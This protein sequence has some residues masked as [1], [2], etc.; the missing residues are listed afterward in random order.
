MTGGRDGPEAPAEAEAAA[1]V[2]AESART[3]VLVEGISDQRAL[4]TL[5]G[6]LGRD[7]GAEGVVIVPMG[8]A[9]AV[10]RNLIR[11]G[12]Q[13]AGLTVVG[14]CDA[15][16]ERYVRRGLERAGLGGPRTRDEL[17]GA[18]FF[19]CDEDLEDEL[20]RAT[21]RAAIEHLL[22]AHGDLGAFDT[23]RQQPAWRH[24]GFEAQVRRWLGA[25]ARRKVLYAHHLVQALPLDRVPRPLTAVLA[26]TG[27]PDRDSG[28]GTAGRRR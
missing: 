20:I 15:A 17:E 11:F 14:L 9:H 4:E 10:A 16:E 22:D 2:R 5:A 12:P 1:L 3:V 13:G 25:G 27:T 8:G 21:G 26:R 18:G 19:V 7:L 6:R 23:L 24:E 28:A